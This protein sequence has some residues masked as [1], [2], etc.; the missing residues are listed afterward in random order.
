MADEK[1]R[2]RRRRLH[3][4]RRRSSESASGSTLHKSRS[5]RSTRSS[6]SHSQSVA[7][8]RELFGASDTFAWAMATGIYW[9]FLLFV[10]HSPSAFL[11]G[12]FVLTGDTDH[13]LHGLAY[14]GFAF[15]LC[16]TAENWCTARSSGRN[17]PLW[18]YAAV[19]LG[20]VVYGYI[21]EQTQPLTGRTREAADWEADILGALAGV[22]TCLILQIFF[23]FESHAPSYYAA[24]Y[25]IGERKRRRRRRKH[26]HHGRRHH[27]DRENRPEAAPP[28]DSTA[29]E[30]EPK[31]EPEP[32]AEPPSDK[33]SGDERTPDR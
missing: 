28:Q 18:I 1:P 21:D 22:C 32:D 33:T 10:M 8:D 9:L 17:P 5:R 24:Q 30:N 6:N 16:R 31:I 20:C 7:A 13:W 12:D 4:R 3:R 25:E 14:Y 2:R 19:F 29:S 11:P 23:V 27:K 15:L 26:R